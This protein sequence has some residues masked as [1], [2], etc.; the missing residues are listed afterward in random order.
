MDEPTLLFQSALKSQYGLALKTDS[1]R[2]AQQLRRQLYAAREAL[3]KEGMYEAD[4]LSFLAQSSG[5]LWLVIRPLAK[6]DLKAIHSTRL[7]NESEIPLG[8]KA[9][10]KSRVRILGNLC[11]VTGDEC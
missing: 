4:R 8:L 10:G 1:Y 3:R 2:S 6:P 11:R 5:E 9:R 7:L